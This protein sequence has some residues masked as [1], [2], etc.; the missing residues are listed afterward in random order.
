MFDTQ[1]ERVDNEI[2]KVDSSIYLKD[3]MTTNTYEF[4]CS[5]LLWCDS[6]FHIFSFNIVIVNG[7]IRLLKIPL[8]I[9]LQ[10][11]EIGILKAFHVL[12]IRK[13]YVL[14]Y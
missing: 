10:V 6:F 12:N 3:S 7:Q 2:K 13:M 1:D 14:C 4:L 11:A 8:T 9:F 5:V